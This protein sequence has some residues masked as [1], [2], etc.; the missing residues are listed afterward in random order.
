MI[1]SIVHLSTKRCSG[2]FD[3][4]EVSTVD[5]D[6]TTIFIRA[7]ALPI[8]KVIAHRICRDPAAIPPVAIDQPR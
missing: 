8:L 5:T 3:G 4:F 1:S 7:K 6:E 2:M